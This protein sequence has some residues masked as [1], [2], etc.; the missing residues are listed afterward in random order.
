MT[1]QAISY[2]TSQ[3]HKLLCPAGL[4]VSNDNPLLLLCCFSHRATSKC[5]QGG[6]STIQSNLISLLPLSAA[7]L[8]RYT[9]RDS[10]VV[11]SFLNAGE[12]MLC[13]DVPCWVLQGQEMQACMVLFLACAATNSLLWR[14]KTRPACAKLIM[15][16]N[17]PHE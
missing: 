14:D 8:N 9:I 11:L 13:V 15:S 4:E 5:L 10:T 7:L 1:D 16:R 6:M 17:H 3:T 12:K 2:Y